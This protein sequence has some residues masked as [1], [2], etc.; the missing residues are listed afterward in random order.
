MV[1]SKQWRKIND[2]KNIANLSIPQSNYDIFV[3]KLSISN[4]FWNPL[5][6]TS[7]PYELLST[8]LCVSH[9]CRRN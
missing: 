5:P 2:K 4:Y 1:I 9:P 6:L 3:F 8:P 7:I